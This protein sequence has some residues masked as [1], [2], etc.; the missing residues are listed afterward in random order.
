MR[1][2]TR[3]ATAVVA[4][5]LL[6][7]TVAAQPAPVS[8]AT[9]QRATTASA[10][11]RPPVQLPATPSPRSGAATGPAA[12]P[13]LPQPADPC[14]DGDLRAAEPA[15]TPPPAALVHG[16]LDPALRR[17][18]ASLR[19]AARPNSGYGTTAAA[20]H[21][22]W[23]LGLIELHG[24]LAPDSPALAQTWFERAAR[25]GREPLA[26]AGLAWCA[27][28]G[29]GGPPDPSAALQAINQL[30]R[31]DRGRALYLKW[32]LDN[33][34]RPLEAR[35][36]QDQDAD[37]PRLPYR[38]QPRPPATR[39]PGSNSAWTPWPVATWRPRAAICSR[40]PRA[41]ALPR[42]TCNCSICTMPRRPIHSPAAPARRRHGNCWSAPAGP[43]TAA[44]KR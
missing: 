20:A 32:L 30:Q 11:D 33:R 7:G 18:L 21:A 4:A 8:T 3:Q 5:A 44:A 6:A 1:L 39:R 41:R 22:A 43:T 2:H 31:H 26:Y 13:G 9:P 28:E 29:C 37:A 25:L 19:R 27:I 17:E 34:S 40:L 15:V 36:R 14:P 42:P 24:G 10:V 12:T 23:T 38:R 16:R 35:T